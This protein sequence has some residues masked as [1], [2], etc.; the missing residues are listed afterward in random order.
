MNRYN[1]IIKQLTK[2]NNQPYQ[3]TLYTAT[4]YNRINPTMS[5]DTTSQHNTTRPVGSKSIQLYSLGTPN[6]QKISIALEELG[7]EYDAHTINIRK[8]EQFQP[9]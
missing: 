6:G 4:K 1:T 7:L 8:N 2:Y 5:T 9:W 3:S